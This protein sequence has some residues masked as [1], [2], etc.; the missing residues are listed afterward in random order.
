M[1]WLVLGSPKFLGP[2]MT[3]KWFD[4]LEHIITHGIVVGDR[5]HP[6]PKQLTILLKL[7]KIRHC[8]CQILAADFMMQFLGSGPVYI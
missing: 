7:V 8:Y 4:Y 3:S 2:L 5:S 1:E 6:C